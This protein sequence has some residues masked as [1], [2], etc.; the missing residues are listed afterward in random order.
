MAGEHMPVDGWVKINAAYKAN[1]HRRNIAHPELPLG[2]PE[3]PMGR[4]DMLELEVA[5]YC[6][7]ACIFDFHRLKSSIWASIKDACPYRFVSINHDDLK[8]AWDNL[9][10]IRGQLKGWEV[11]R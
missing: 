5:N 11:P 8:G 2:L 3:N 7:L 1:L 4:M 6:Q 9:L 10:W